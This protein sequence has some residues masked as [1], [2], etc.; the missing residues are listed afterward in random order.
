[1]SPGFVL[2]DNQLEQNK[3]ILGTE[4]KWVLRGHESRTLYYKL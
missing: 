2:P 3:N 1:L 4:M